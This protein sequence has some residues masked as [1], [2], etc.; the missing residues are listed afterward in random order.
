[1]AISKKIRAAIEGS[2]WIRRMFEQGAELKARYFVPRILEIR[3]VVTKGTG[4][5][6][7]VL[8][9]DG[10]YTFRIQG[11]DDLDGSAPPAITVKDEHGHRYRI[12]DYWEL[13]RDSRE[14][15]RDLLPD[16][17]LRARYGKGRIGKHTRGGMVGGF[18]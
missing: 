6:W 12:E 18:R 1:M 8:T 5:L 17:I 16:K 7:D 14:C 3:S 13:D 11:R 9:D 15:I 4:K 10:A 2:S